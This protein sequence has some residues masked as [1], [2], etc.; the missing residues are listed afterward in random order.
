MYNFCIFFIQTI[1]CKLYFFVLFYFSLRHWKMYM[2]HLILKIKLKKK[3][4]IYI[5]IHIYFLLLL[6]FVFK[7]FYV[8]CTHNNTKNFI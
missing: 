1:F 8:N 7:G 3:K 5:Y 6:L 4:Y 2:H